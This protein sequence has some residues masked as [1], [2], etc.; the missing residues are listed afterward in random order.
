MPAWFL[1][2]DKGEGDDCLHHAGLEY[3]RPCVS[4]LEFQIV[5]SV[6]Y[7]EENRVG[8]L[9]CDFSFHVF[10]ESEGGL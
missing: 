7:L 3:R 5:L 1:Q 6:M 8:S 2:S 10:K 4:P 9:F